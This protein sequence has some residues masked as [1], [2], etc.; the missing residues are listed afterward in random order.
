MGT[1]ADNGFHFS[2]KGPAQGDHPGDSS[3]GK[4]SLMNMYVNRK[5]NNQYKA[6]IGADFLTKEDLVNHNGD[7]R[8]VTMQIWDTAGQERFQSLGVAFY[9]GADACILVFDL[10]S[11]KSF[12]NLDTWREEFLVQSGPSDTESFPFVVLGNKWDLKEHRVVNDKQVIEYCKNQKI[13]SKDGET[14]MYF[15]TSAKESKDVNKAFT[16]VATLAL[17]KQP[18]DGLAQNYVPDANLNLDDKKPDAGKKGCAC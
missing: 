16:T 7:Q 13:M 12:D 17:E 11:R 8:L 2:Q 10:T 3:V 18:D 15:E 4:T 1:D 5:F 6:T 9:R 14:P